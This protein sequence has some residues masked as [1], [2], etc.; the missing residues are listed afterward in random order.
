MKNQLYNFQILYKIKQKL[1]K[2]YKNINN[3]INYKYKYN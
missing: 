2:Y 3:Y 1:Y